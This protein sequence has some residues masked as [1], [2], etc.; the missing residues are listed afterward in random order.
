MIEA[1]NLSYT[2][3]DGTKALQ[4]L[5]LIIGEGEM[6]AFIGQN[7]SGKTTFAKVICGLQPK[8]GG[9]IAIDGK[10][11]K[12]Y[13][14]RELAQKI[15][16][17]FQNPDHQLFSSSVEKEITSGPLN[18]GLSGS[19]VRERLREAAEI[20]GVAQSLFSSHP[21]FLS[22]GLRQRVAIASVLAM[23]P[24]HIIVDEPTTG[25]DHRQAYGVMEF[26]RSL[27][28]NT[29]H[30]IIIITHE[31][32][33]VARYASRAIIFR[34]GR[35]LLDDATE[36]VFSQVSAMEQARVRP[37]QITVFS[38]QVLN[39]T[40]LTVDEAADS[41]LHMKDNREEEDYDDSP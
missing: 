25:Q 26:L 9:E 16:Y 7:G 21:F 22:K 5:S 27:N 35:I 30:T 10:P 15:G 8:W 12:R 37:P 24:N 17:V 41:L 32:H 40:L 20:A 2:Y 4:D 29:K 18:L 14:R 36:R 28:A 19:E 1:R 39:R 38:Q 6:P 33:I 23:R 3:P 31:M 13:K 34:E 11:L